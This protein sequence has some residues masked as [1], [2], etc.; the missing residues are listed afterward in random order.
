[1]LKWSFKLNN[2]EKLKRKQPNKLTPATRQLL[3][4]LYDFGKYKTIKNTVKVDT[5]DDN[6]QSFDADTVVRFRCTSTFCTS[7]PERSV[8]VEF[9][10]KKL[11]EDN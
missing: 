3:K 1:M 7:T 6:L 4:F 10:S 8:V 9:S 2:Y 11:E 5:V